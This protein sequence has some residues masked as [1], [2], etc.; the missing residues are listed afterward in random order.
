[1]PHDDLDELLLGSI[2][3]AASV[4]I[5]DLDAR[6]PAPGDTISHYRILETIGEGGMGVVCKAIDLKLDRV[7]ALKLLLPFAG[8]DRQLREQLEREAR[9]ASALNHPSICT[10]HDFDQTVD[11]HHFIVMEYLEG[12]TVK[13]RLARGALP[14][15]EA[16]H[17]ALEVA[18][19][20]EA[21]H[22]RNLVH[23]DVKP[24]NIFLTSRG[25]T[26]VLDFGIVRLQRDVPTEVR[27]A[28]KDPLSSGTRAYMSP[29][30]ARGEELDRRSDIFSLGA[31]LRD[32]VSS[33]GPALGAA[34]A[35]MTAPERSL[36]YQSMAEATAALRE[37]LNRNSRRRR[38]AI[39]GTVAVAAAIVLIG[40][41]AATGWRPWSRAPLLVERDWILIAHVANDT[42]EP[43]FDEVLRDAVAVQFGQSPFLTVFS[44]ARI[45][46]QLKLM[47]RPPDAPLTADVARDLCARAGIKAFVTGAIRR[48][49]SR[50][51]V[52]LQ[53]MNA[54]TGDTIA[55]EQQEVGGQAEV[56]HAIGRAASAMRPALG[57]SL[58]SIA[59]F[60]VPL[61]TA[62]TSSLEAL[63]AFQRGQSLMAQGTSA[64]LKAVPFFQRAIELDPEFALAYARLAVAYENAREQKRSEQAT[65]EAFA[66]R[67]RVSERERYQIS[68]RYYGQVS[69]EVSKAIEALEMWTHSYPADGSPHN[70]LMAYL[71]DLGRLEQA[72]DHGETALRL[73]P[74][75][76]I[77]RSN[78][79]GAY[80]RLG[81]FDRAAAICA[82][83]VRD[84][85]DNTTIHRFLHTIAIIKGDHA[86][87]AREN[88]WRAKTTSDYANT[89]YAG[90]IAGAQGRLREAR[91]QYRQAIAL[92]E[93]QGLSDRAAEY[94]VRLA[95]LELYSGRTAA[96]A[97]V[98]KEVLAADPSRLLAA[99]AAFVLASAGDPDGGLALDRLLRQFPEDEL[100]KNLWQPLIRGAG[101]LRAGRAA[102]ALDD[103]R[104]L[105][106]YDRGDHAMMRPSYYA[107][108]ARLAL[109]APR[110]ARAA[111][112]KIV[113]NRGVVRTSPLFALAHL[114]LARAAVLDGTPAEARAAYEKFFAVWKD[115]DAD[116]PVLREAR[117]EYARLKG[118]L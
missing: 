58:Q 64:A 66:R 55:H 82:D 92:T 21:A 47:R 111:F 1:M 10:I 87:I 104:L 53:A 115:A 48:V 24:A 70:S 83:A 63:R 85:V 40:V 32:M 116:L 18:S 37:T 106:S 89:E 52:R 16:V 93:R 57:E 8:N 14:E 20:L 4:F 45:Q 11:G 6:R 74:A 3:R 99:D 33:P 35:R 2:G 30:Q 77:Y 71:K 22:A 26:K 59:R 114:G 105:E 90:S 29:E 68:A 42:G 56:V 86:G 38:Q 7:V 101:A 31:M 49:G 91:D 113:D 28:S 34:I 51:I 76:P 23:C 36:R 13:A 103:L 117:A 102:A 67:L 112:Q 108:A 100:L 79:A 72:A 60:D 88:A 9:A 46:E 5:G 75:S 81:Q 50:Y 27:Q 98:A 94:R 61:E 17:I 69:G 41:A 25:G 110:D 96:A 12:E 62:T 44:G 19:A 80:L 107:G 54:A 39:Y 43:I 84:K 73:A 97:A 78:L 95:L 65:V 15:A 118:G 109:R